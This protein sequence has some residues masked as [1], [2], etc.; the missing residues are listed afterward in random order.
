[1]KIV[2]SFFQK[3]NTA[4][5]NFLIS[6]L[7]SPRDTCSLCKERGKFLLTF[8][9]FKSN[10]IIAYDKVLGEWVIFDEDNMFIKICIL[11]GEINK[12]YE[13]TETLYLKINNYCRNCINKEMRKMKDEKKLL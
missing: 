9:K 10:H 6:T 1:M 11:S 12:F 5:Y 13:L 8:T 4:V 2:N 3:I 7:P